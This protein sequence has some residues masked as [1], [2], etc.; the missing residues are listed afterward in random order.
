[1]TVLSLSSCLFF[2]FPFSMNFWILINHPDDTLEAESTLSRSYF[3]NKPSHSRSAFISSWLQLFPSLLKIAAA[4]LVLKEKS[5]IS[6]TENHGDVHW[7]SFIFGDCLS[8]LG[9]I[10]KSGIWKSEAAITRMYFFEYISRLTVNNLLNK[11]INM[12]G[13]VKLYLCDTMVNQLF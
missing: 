5:S 11:Y 13:E 1:M 6:N 3:S 10:W 9:H 2:L 4:P 7:V 12:K 8:I